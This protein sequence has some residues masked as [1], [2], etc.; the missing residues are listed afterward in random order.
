MIT[1]ELNRARSHRLF[2]HLHGPVPVMYNY[3]SGCIGRAGFVF[4]LT[5]YKYLASRVYTGHFQ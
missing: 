2:L 4:V 3:G 1:S 5:D